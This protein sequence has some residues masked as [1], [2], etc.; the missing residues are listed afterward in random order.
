MVLSTH[1]LSSHPLFSSISGVRARGGLAKGAARLEKNGGGANGLERT[2]KEP[3]WSGVCVALGSPLGSQA[4][5]P[6]SRKVR[7]R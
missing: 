5:C 2:G 4:G 6:C 7:L 1:R 3:R